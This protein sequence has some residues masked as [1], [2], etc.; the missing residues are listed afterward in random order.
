MTR[1]LSSLLKGGWVELK[2][3][4]T[5]I[6]DTNDLVNQ[7]LAGLSQSVT[8]PSYTTLGEPDEDGFASG[9]SAQILEGLTAPG[10]D[11]DTAVIHQ[12]PVLEGP[13][14][15]ETRQ[16]VEQ[17]LADAQA[18]VDAARREADN[19]RGDAAREAQNI[20]ENARQEG[21]QQ[22]YQEGMQQAEQEAASK[23]A[24]L[25]QKEQAL[26]SA[27]DAKF[28]ELEPQFIDHLT[29]IYEHIFH[30]EL[31]SYREILSYLI[32]NTMRKVDGNRNFFIHV[33][34]EDYPFISM[35]KKQIAAA[36]AAGSSIEVVEDLTLSK[37]ECMIETED[38]VF[39]CGV[40]T[41]LTELSN[42]L[43]L[44]SYEKE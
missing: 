41:Q 21:L 36:V 1:L 7:R 40:G 4:E 35:Q 32:A 2:S 24:Q 33:S 34:K 6:I 26:E 15:E 20:R 10:E 27:Y 30:V 44:L 29:A 11:G 25:D 37:N 16:Q 28:K 3:E 18:Q 39:D 23:M 19:I 31:R 8:K 43:K 38:G 5:R 17:M 42:R 22:G 12:D 9:V 13:S 14:L